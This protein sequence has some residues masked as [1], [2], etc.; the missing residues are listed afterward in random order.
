M[1]KVTLWALL[2]LLVGAAVL[3]SA[4]SRSRAAGDE[5]KAITIGA[6]VPDF[7]LPDTNGTERSLASLKG[8]K[9][10]LVFFTSAR[11]PM[12]AAYHERIQQIAQDYQAKGIAV[13]G[14]NSNVT[15]NA[16]EIKQHA[17]NNK[18]AYVV[19]RD[20]DSKLA[21]TLNAQVTP[22]MYLLD[23]NN[24][25]VYHGGVDDSRSPDKVTNNYLRNALDA[26]LAGKPI[27]QS[28]TKAFGCTVK[29]A[30]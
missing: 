18:L 10:T 13:V 20:A 12:V 22:E 21:D 17:A 14:I 1:K 30:S 26:F 16:E 8:S 4:P 25:L 28:E 29:R 3:I 15:E 27:A 19:L 24:K 23:T 6:V 2:V 5:A 11:C 7:S 9:G